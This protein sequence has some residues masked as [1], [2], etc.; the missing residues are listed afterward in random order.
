MHGSRRASSGAGFLRFLRDSHIF[1]AAIHEIL[2]VKLLQE[3]SPCP[4]TPSQLH[5]LKLMSLNGHHQ[6]GQVADLLGVSPPAATKNIDKLE[7]LGLVVREP[8]KGDRRATL[9][10]VSRRGR[11]L[12]QKYEELRAAR[13]TPV[14]EDFRAEEIEQFTRLLERFSVSLLSQEMSGAGFCLRCA[15][16]IEDD[17]PV[18]Q[19]HG[20]CRYQHVHDARQSEGLAE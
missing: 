7:R 8:S 2:D 9:L 19:V 11:R 10:S 18:G 1:A 20:G 14:L 13:L 17:C 6:V 15:G 12:V 4:L 16:Y 3:V 5:I